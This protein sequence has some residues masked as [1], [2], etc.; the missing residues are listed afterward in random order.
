[1][2]SEVGEYR[3]VCRFADLAPGTLQA[4]WPEAN[5]LLPRALDPASKEPDFNVRVILEGVEP[6]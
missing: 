1:L 5:V 6:I 4:Y 3:G 2:R